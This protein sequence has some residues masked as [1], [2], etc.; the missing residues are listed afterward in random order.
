[1]RKVFALCSALLLTVM[2]AVPAFADVWIP[3][4]EQS[5]NQ[6]WIWIGAFV[7]LVVIV[8]LLVLKHKRGK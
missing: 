5:G 8:L 6:Q 1:M 7:L 2:L 4:E 3:P